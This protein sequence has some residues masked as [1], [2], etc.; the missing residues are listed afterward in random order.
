MSPVSV[1]LLAKK[2]KT[3]VPHHF[4]R[5]NTRKIIRNFFNKTKLCSGPAVH[6]SHYAKFE[7]KG[8]KSV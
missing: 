8:M 6:I 4:V 1:L 7:Y 2:A 5:H 3:P